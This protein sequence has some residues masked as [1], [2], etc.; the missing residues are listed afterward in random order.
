MSDFDERPSRVDAAVGQSIERVRKDIERNY[1][2]SAS[3][4]VDYGLVRKIANSIEE[5]MLWPG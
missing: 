2:M 4:A 3:E 1:W 5:L